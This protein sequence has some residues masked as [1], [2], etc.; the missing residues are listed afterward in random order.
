MEYNYQLRP[1]DY[2]DFLR[3]P[4]RT[5]C[6]NFDPT[7][8]HAVMRIEV[9]EFQKVTFAGLTHATGVKGAQCYE[10]HDYFLRR[11]GPRYRWAM[12]GWRCLQCKRVFFGHWADD[13]FSYVQ[14]ECTE[15]IIEC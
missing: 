7:D 6:V 4:L 13:D 10:V 15:R 11:V 2:G 12:D 3:V 14:H 5:R 9:V 8:F 1:Y